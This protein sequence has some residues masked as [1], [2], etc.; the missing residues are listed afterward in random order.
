MNSVVVGKNDRSGSPSPQS[1]AEFSQRSTPRALTLLGLG[2]AILLSST[3]VFAQ[4]NVFR[5]S[6]LQGGSPI[7]PQAGPTCSGGSAA[8]D[9]SI[10]E[11]YRVGAPDVRIVQ[12]LL[13]PNYPSILSRVCTCWLTGTDPSAMSFNFM[14]YDDDGPSGTPGTFL[15]SVP[16]TVNIGAPFSSAFV[17]E[18]CT[19]LGIHLA[20]GGAY[21][22]VQ[23]NGVANEDL[24][25]CADESPST[26]LAQ[27]YQS[28]SGG[29]SW[30]PITDFFEADRALMVRAE[31]VNDTGP[32][33]LPPDGPWIT[34]TALPGFQFKSRIDNIR[35]ATKVTDCVPETL[36]LAGAIPT[37]S[38]VFVRIIGPRPNGFL[39]PEVIRFTTSQVELWVQKT[40][41]GPINYYNLAGV[42]QNSDVLNGLVDRE[43]FTP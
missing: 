40:S 37:R 6:D 22:G 23:W 4:T 19:S 32:D 10:E 1:L 18:S 12:R 20:S 21:V 39:W 41:G 5:F 28:T 35:I 34:T 27:V 7:E 16:S 25:I 36:C 38:E 9:G 14:V 33:P 15:G 13:P 43:G 24:F 31:F 11:G 26:P 29:N 2:V 30:N 8:D 42:S 3:G 17:G